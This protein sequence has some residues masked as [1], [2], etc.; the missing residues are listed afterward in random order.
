MVLW[1]FLCVR[2]SCKS[3]KNAC[4]FFP[5]VWAFVGWLILVYLGLEGSGFGV[6]VFFLFFFFV[7]LCFCFFWEGL[8]VR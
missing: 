4:L 2:Y 6:F 8:R 5:V 1:L 7:F 3:V